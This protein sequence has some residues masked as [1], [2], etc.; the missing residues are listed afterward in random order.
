ME[1][2]VLYFRPNIQYLIF[3]EELRKTTIFI[4]QDRRFL[5]QHLIRNLQNMKQEC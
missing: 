3:L 1:V 5:D 2:V 4:S